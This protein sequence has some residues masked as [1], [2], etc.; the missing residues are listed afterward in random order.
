MSLIV[1]E[2]RTY[3][4]DPVRLAAFRTAIEAIV[5]P[6]S[7]VLDLAAGTGILGLMACR[8]GASRVYSIESGGMVEVARQV[9]RD[10][11]FADRITFLK[12]FSTHASL[13]ERVDVVVADQV[14]NFGFNAGI[15]EYFAD[16][17]AR[18]LKPGGVTI[19][20]RIDLVACP[21][22]APGLSAQ[23]E[24]W[25][26]APGG[27]DFRSTREL[28]ANTGYQV[29]FPG[30]GFLAPPATIASL[31]LNHASVAPI[32]GR[33][34]FRADRAAVL[35]GIG[36]WFVAELA[37]G[38]T[39]TNS[40][41]A[42]DRIQRRQ[43]FFPVD[44]PTTVSVGDAIRVEMAI[45]PV[46]SLVNWSVEVASGGDGKVTAAF[47]HSTW[48]GMLL[49]QEDIARTRPDFVPRLNAR[50]EA[51]RTVVELCDGERTVARIEAELMAR[52]PGLFAT[53][54]EAATF[55]AEVVTR[56]AE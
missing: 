48:K 21:V 34:G 20:S 49:N 32:H 12:Q 43:V 5:R 8:A 52:H 46:D 19:P 41:L 40:P 1:D 9:A 4:S 54:E 24:F 2:H 50:G 18:F 45:R 47:R 42:K 11:G 55:V 30:T 25:D 35:H 16:A 27:F 44:R 17:R 6:G 3:L 22:E 31:D 33:A 51:R 38:V 13:P 26:T 10:N 29:D 37:P 39:M 36:G 7:V 15:L 14:G 28:A 53:R 23:V 56:Y